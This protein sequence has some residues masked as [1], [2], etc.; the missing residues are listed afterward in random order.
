MKVEVKTALRQLMNSKALGT[1]EILSRVL[2][3][4]IYSSDINMIRIINASVL[5]N[6]FPNKWKIGKIIS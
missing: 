6:K 1:D 4:G 5:G 2:V 3:D